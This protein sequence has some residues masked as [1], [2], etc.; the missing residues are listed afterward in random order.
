[1]KNIIKEIKNKIQWGG[2]EGRLKKIYKDLQVR[3]GPFA[4]MHYTSFVSVGGALYPELIGVYEREI[5]DIVE[6]CIKQKYEY[7]VDVGCARGYYAVGMAKFG[8]VEK[9]VAYDIDDRA[10]RLCKE[11]AFVNNVKVE[12]RRRM[13]A[14]DLAKFPFDKTKKSF[15]MVDCEGFERELF[16]EAAIKNLANVECLIEVHDWCQ[17][18]KRTKDMLLNMFE[19]THRC[20]VIEGVD[21]YDKAYD[22]KIEELMDFSIQQRLWIFAEGR[23]RLGMWIFCS[24]KLYDE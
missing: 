21:D 6:Y 8:K 19:A 24:P 18:E 5:A 20:S 13:T 23:R 12:V 10:R 15:I 4:G 17:Y 16:S 2:V 22:Y 7:F 3:R 11:M 9:V 1:M 14:D